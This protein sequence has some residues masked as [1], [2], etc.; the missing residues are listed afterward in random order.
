MGIPFHFIRSLLV[1]AFVFVPDLGNTQDSRVWTEAETNRQIK[2][3]LARLEGDEALLILKGG[4]SVRVPVDRLSKS[5]ILYL[6]ELGEIQKPSQAEA[7]SEEIAKRLQ[8]A[9]LGKVLKEADFSKPLSAEDGWVHGNGEWKSEGG[10]LAG[11]ERPEQNHVAACLWRNPLQDVVAAVEFRVSGADQVMFRFDAEKGHLG[12][13]SISPTKGRITV[14][15]QNYTRTPATPPGWLHSELYEV[16]ENRWYSVIVESIGDT[17]VCHLDDH[18][19][20]GSDDACALPKKTFG[21]VVANQ[22]A[23]F[24]NLVIWE[25]SSAD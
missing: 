20:R 14:A 23:E 2:A 11:A 17:W 5:D 8:I 25:A 10:I 9:R 6:Q 16:E 4:R 18:V 13:F 24:R 15:K 21:F 22:K 12:G 7:L 3:K 1:L 19:I